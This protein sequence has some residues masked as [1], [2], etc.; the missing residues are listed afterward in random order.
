[1]TLRCPSDQVAIYIPPVASSTIPP[2]KALPICKRFLE[3]VAGRPVEDARVYDDRGAEITIVEEGLFSK[4]EGETPAFEALL[5]DVERGTVRALLLAEPRA[6]GKIPDRNAAKRLDDQVEVVYATSFLAVVPTDETME[7]LHRGAA[8]P[9]RYR[10]FPLM[11]RRAKQRSGAPPFVGAPCDLV[12]AFLA[13]DSLSSWCRIASAA[14][15]AALDDQGAHMQAQAVRH[16]EAW[17][18]DGAE[19]SGLSDADPEKAYWATI[20]RARGH[21]VDGEWDAAAEQVRAARKLP[22]DETASTLEGRL[23]AA[24]DFGG[25]AF[26]KGWEGFTV[27]AT[28]EALFGTPWVPSAPVAFAVGLSK[29]ESALRNVTFLLTRAPNDRDPELREALDRLA[30]ALPHDRAEMLRAVTRPYRAPSKAK[31]RV[32]AAGAKKTKAKVK[33]T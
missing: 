30:A 4:I 5:A 15:F 29:Q 26:A 17:L 2:E 1:M 27:S 16:F 32:K 33:K 8:D 21:L 10:L 23:L 3:A 6:L 24:A 25:G 13:R 7:E 12:E 22:R 14:A 18:R 20:E 31:K 28:Q 19:Q 11:G 9:W